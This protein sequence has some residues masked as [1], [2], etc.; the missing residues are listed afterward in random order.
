MGWAGVSRAAR[1]P[2]A[3]PANGSSSGAVISVRKPRRSP[4]CSPFAMALRIPASLAA[5][6]SV[7]STVAASGRPGRPR[8]RRRRP[9]CSR[10]ADHDTAELDRDLGLADPPVRAD[11]RVDPGREAPG[12]PI[13]RSA[14]RSRTGPS[15]DDAG[16]AVCLRLHRHQLAEQGPALVALAVDDD[17]LARASPPSGLVHGDDAAGVALDGVGRP[18]HPES[19]HDRS[20]SSGGAPRSSSA[21]RRRSRL[22]GGRAARS[23]RRS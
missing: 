7:A 13:P 6:A 8:R 14:A 4:S 10:R 17:D 11:P 1:A 15:I 12:S 22:P 2:Q 23:E 20:G 18:D 19:R 5:T 21:H 3:T 16:D 9:G